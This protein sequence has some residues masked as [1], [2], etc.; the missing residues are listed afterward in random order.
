[1]SAS[2]TTVR[3]E[4]L[5][6]VDDDPAILSQL[7]L[8]LS[9]EFEVYTSNAPK[10]ALE[11][12]E[13]E[14]PHLV[15]LDLALEL[16]DPESGFSLLEACLERDPLMKIVLISG[17]DTQANA[18]RAIDQG[19]F[20]F[21]GKP[22]DLE[23]LRFMLRRAASIGRLERQNEELLQSFGDEERLGQ[24]L[25][26][27]PKMRSVFSLMEKVAPVDVSVLILG[28]SG[29]GKELAAREIRRLSRR[30]TKPFASISCASIPETLLEGELFGHEKGSFTGAHVS[31]PGKLELADGGTIFLDEIGEIPLLLQ[32]K[33][34][35]FLQE[36]EVERIGGRSVIP[37]DV[38]VIAATNRDLEDE[39][40]AG[41]FREDL[42]YRL[43]VVNVNLPPLRERDEDVLHLAQYFLKKFCGEFNR[44][45]LS[46]SR[47]ATL[48]LQK[49][50]WPGNVRELEHR[51]QR[52][53]VLSSGKVIQKSDL[54]IP[55]SKVRDSLSL[56]GV[57]ERTERSTIIEAMQQSCGNISKAASK[58]EISRPTLHDLLR[59][60]GIEAAQFKATQTARRHASQPAAS[61][62]VD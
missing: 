29:T 40:R 55:E 56:R 57:R 59:K 17:N 14:H 26:Q 61:K 54:Q 44:G 22:V 51:I 62:E 11:I 18:R 28:E 27:S 60:Y 20:D 52:A 7:S 16:Q 47:A 39:V 15:T 49:Y 58:L 37:L 46:L 30:A 12:V 9:D 34:L 2:L 10:E 32:S 23:V 3:A 21:F 1:M 42:F 43:S 19:A 53:V 45:K 41:R 13:K 33:L 31:R 8:A 38:R 35:R 48:A 36:H 6:I 4:K 24:L 50:E 5:L 25:G